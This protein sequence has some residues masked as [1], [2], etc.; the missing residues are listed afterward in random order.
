[1]NEHIDKQKSPRKTGHRQERF[2][3]G[4]LGHLA[5]WASVS[6][7]QAQSWNKPAQ[8]LIKGLERFVNADDSLDDY[9]ALAKAFPSFWPLPL[10]DGHGHDISWVH[11]AHCLFL[12]YRNLLRRFWTRDPLAL[13]D[14]F[15]T[16]LLFGTLE[17]DKVHNI[18]A[19]K[20]HVSFALEEALAPLTNTYPGLCVPSGPQPFA[21]FWP[22]WSTGDVA[23]I[24]QIDFQRAIWLFFR[25]SWRA[26]V[27]PKCSTY[28]FVQ[29]SA[30]L[31]CS[32]SC[33]N[34][35]HQASSL[36]WWKEKGSRRRAARMKASDKERKH[37]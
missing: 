17:R 21:L 5:V 36:R 12:F 13:K 35:A 6:S 25:E 37:Q 11:D 1:M 20:E 31:Y 7:Y 3:V 33:S 19:G 22:D 2:G 26:K 24:S 16:R 18:F 14:G 10:E 23:Y 32:L 15:N 28:F 4:H 30:Q 27:C 34:S 29:K 9:Q 8:W